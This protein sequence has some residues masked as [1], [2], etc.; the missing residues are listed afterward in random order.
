MLIFFGLNF[1]ISQ[2]SKVV[3]G[4]QLNYIFVHYF[5]F[6]LNVY[7]NARYKHYGLGL[8]TTEKAIIRK[9]KHLDEE[10]SEDEEVIYKI[11]IPAN[12]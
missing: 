5:N 1:F 7:G 4:L 3:L 9:E 6:N 10:A 11:E 2:T 8:Q 12:R